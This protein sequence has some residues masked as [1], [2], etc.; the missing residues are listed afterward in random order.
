MQVLSLGS[1]KTRHRSIIKIAFVTTKKIYLLKK[2]K[3]SCMSSSE[4]PVH[5]VGK[6]DHSIIL[7]FEGMILAITFSFEIQILSVQYLHY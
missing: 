5:C 4:P 1:N 2:K 7:Q 6:I 3:K